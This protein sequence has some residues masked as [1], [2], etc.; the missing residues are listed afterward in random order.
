MIDEGDG[1]VQPYGDLDA[2]TVAVREL[3]GASRE[4]VGRM[5][6]LMA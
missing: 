3:I 1:A 4:M 2:A 5:A 6:H